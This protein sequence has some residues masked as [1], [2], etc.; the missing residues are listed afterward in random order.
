MERQE[1]VNSQAIELKKTFKS[2]PPAPNNKRAKVKRSE[3]AYPTSNNGAEVLS[4]LTTIS[5]ILS[6]YLVHN[7]YFV[8][9][10]LVNRLINE[11]V[12]NIPGTSVQNS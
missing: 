6:I 11:F 9:G 10:N 5:Q 8:N 7:M 1:A 2:L 3:M 12:N 4:S